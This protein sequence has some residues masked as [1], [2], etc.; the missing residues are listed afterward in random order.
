MDEIEKEYELA[1]N[2]IVLA[3]ESRSLS[4]E[5]MDATENFDFE[6]SENLIK[7]A[8]EQF[9]ECHKLHAELLTNEANGNKYD[10]NIIMV[11]AQDHLTLATMAID[12]AKRLLKLYKKLKKMEGGK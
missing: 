1:F 3:G 6:S 4:N 2:I 9:Y 5:S 11:H 10:V 7:K 8:Q 12:N